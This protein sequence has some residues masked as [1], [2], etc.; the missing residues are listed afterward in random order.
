[1]EVEEEERAR[2]YFYPGFNLCGHQL[3]I[4]FIFYICE[5]HPLDQAI[6]SA[7]TVYVADRLQRIF[8]D[9]PFGNALRI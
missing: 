6:I 9:E 8:R 3:L 4:N 5:K 2:I 1:V 7:R